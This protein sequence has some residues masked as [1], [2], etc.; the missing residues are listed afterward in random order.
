MIEVK[1]LNEPCPYCRRPIT[2]LS[3]A[4]NYRC[5][6]GAWRETK[7]VRHWVA[8][9]IEE[10]K[11]VDS[12]PG[13]VPVDDMNLSEGAKLLFTE[14]QSI[15]MGFMNRT[16][17]VESQ[18]NLI[19]ATAYVNAKKRAEEGDQWSV[20][21]VAVMDKQ[22]AHLKDIGDRYLLDVAKAVEA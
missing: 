18:L 9:V 10:A 12:V 15:A 8:P 22:I 16:V 2:A 1:D 17:A 7:P 4:G 6:C 13:L 19:V 5:H 11:N 20:D 14:M 3:N 21:L